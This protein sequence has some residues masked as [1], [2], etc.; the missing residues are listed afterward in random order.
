MLPATRGVMGADL[1]TDMGFD[2]EVVGALSFMHSRNILH[3]D[4]LH[5]G[6]LAP[7]IFYLRNP[8]CVSGLK[9]QLEPRY[10]PKLHVAS[11]ALLPR[12]LARTLAH[13]ARDPAPLG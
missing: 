11:T 5:R 6:L 10:M 3:R 13:G 9:L 4:Q 1:L 8:S 12:L 2:C 7:R